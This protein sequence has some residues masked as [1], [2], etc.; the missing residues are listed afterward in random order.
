MEAWMECEIL[1]KKTESIPEEKMENVKEEEGT[2]EI[3]LRF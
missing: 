1:E 2:G 3:W